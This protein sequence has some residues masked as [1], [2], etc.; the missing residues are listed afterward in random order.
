MCYFTGGIVPDLLD[1]RGPG[2][3]RIISAPRED[4]SDDYMKH[5]L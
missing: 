5:E 3:D 2:P 1:C 4:D